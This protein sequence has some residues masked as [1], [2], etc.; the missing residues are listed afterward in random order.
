MWTRPGI[1]PAS[2]CTCA[3][4]EVIRVRAEQLVL[5]DIE[6]RALQCSLTAEQIA[7]KTAELQSQVGF[8]P[9][10][11]NLWRVIA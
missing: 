6:L 11:C 4:A 10:E 2:S 5:G 9:D 3:L 8:L 1:S 7:A